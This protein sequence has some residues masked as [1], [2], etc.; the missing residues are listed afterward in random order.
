VGYVY[1]TESAAS[2]ETV[3][4]D[5]KTSAFRSSC[6]DD[7]K[8]NRRFGMDNYVLEDDSLQGYSAV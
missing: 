6:N 5:T 3:N 4:I 2:E 7:E 8:M 1:E